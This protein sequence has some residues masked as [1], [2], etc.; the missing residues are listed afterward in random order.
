MIRAILF[1]LGDTLMCPSAAWP[2][3]IERADRA[4]VDVLCKAGLGLDCDHFHEDFKTHLQHYYAE[5]DSQQIETSTSVVLQEL[6]REKGYKSVPPALIRAALDARYR[7]SQSNWQL[8]DDALTSLQMLQMNGCRLAIVSNAGDNKD[9]FQLVDKFGIEPYFDFVLTSAACGWRKP[10]RR[11]FEMALS[12]W[13]Y[14]PAEVAMVGDRLEADIVGANLVGIFSIWAKRY[15]R[16]PA[17]V[18]TA[19]NAQVE[20]LSE[21]PNILKAI[22]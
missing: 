11:I 9:V 4:V 6:L 5:R 21:I 8:V 14:L 7:I 10:N 12:H 13:G 16:T 1:D 15:A 17:E 22:R 18:D 2:A 20:T 19:P 3:V